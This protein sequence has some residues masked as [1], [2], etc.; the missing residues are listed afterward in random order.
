MI[1]RA[2]A[3]VHLRSMTIVRALVVTV[4][5]MVTE[6]LVTAVVVGPAAAA[7]EAARRAKA[8][9]F[10]WNLIDYKLIS[11]TRFYTPN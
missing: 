9:D 3:Q 4:G 1:A 7:T 2:A 10:I 8:K 5:A 6:E 11:L